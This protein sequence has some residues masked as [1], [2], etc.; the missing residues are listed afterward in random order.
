M[1]PGHYTMNTV[2]TK[3][4]CSDVFGCYKGVEEHWSLC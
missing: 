4:K 1:T 3:L 2:Y